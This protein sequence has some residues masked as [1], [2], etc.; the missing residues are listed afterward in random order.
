MVN[1]TCL[2]MRYDWS[3]GSVAMSLS[4]CNLELTVCTSVGSGNNKKAS[5]FCPYDSIQLKI[6]IRNATAKD[7]DRGRKKRR[8]NVLLS[9][10]KVVLVIT[11]KYYV[12]FFVNT[13][14]NWKLFFPHKLSWL[15]S[16]WRNIW[17][18]E[19]D[20]EWKNSEIWPRIWH[21]KFDY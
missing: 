15:F 14:K 20:L 4:W 10:Q 13:R 21:E 3:D 17:S 1:L 18:F 11:F 8:T 7:K 9:Y 19:P 6:E 16:R 12:N 5:C 2:G